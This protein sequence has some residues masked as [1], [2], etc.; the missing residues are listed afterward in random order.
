MKLK[1]LISPFVFVTCIV[2]AF[3]YLDNIVRFLVIES[4]F[5]TEK[6]YV[7]S[8]GLH[9]ETSGS[10]LMQTSQTI[11]VA[12]I[13]LKST[14]TEL[15]DAQLLSKFKAGDSIY[16]CFKYQ[17]YRFSPEN[18]RIEVGDV[19]LSIDKLKTVAQ[20]EKEYKTKSDEVVSQYQNITMIICCGLLTLSVLIFFV[21]FVHQ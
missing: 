18:K 17:Q 21:K 16:V 6:G 19:A 15:K 9:T 7:V 2:I 3:S 8:V 10:F 4:K 5:Q 14:T 12:M 20:L 13:K 11:P 1:K